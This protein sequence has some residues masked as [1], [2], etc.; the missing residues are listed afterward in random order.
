MT[1]TAAPSSES[2]ASQR[3]SGES[4]S[5]DA[6]LSTGIVKPAGVTVRP[7]G[8]TEAID[9]EGATSIV[10]AKTAASSREERAMI[11][12]RRLRARG[13][14]WVNGRR[15]VLVLFGTRGVRL[16]R[17]EEAAERDLVADP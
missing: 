17:D 14:V 15:R 2:T 7:S 8:I 3:P 12:T 16:E 11:I 4:A 1:S 6:K 9:K 10:A 5:A 13:E